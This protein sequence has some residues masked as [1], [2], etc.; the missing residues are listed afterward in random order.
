MSKPFLSDFGHLADT[1]SAT[2]VLDGTCV[3]SPG[4]DPCLQEF[5][6]CLQR[7]ESS[8][9]LGPAMTTVTPDQDRH[10][11]RTQDKQKAAEPSGL[12]FTHHEA[13]STCLPLNGIN[14]LL[15]NLPLDCGFSPSAWQTIA[16]VKVFKKA[17]V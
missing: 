9:R 14:T 8:R 5:L 11:W 4:T 3:P 15:R 7:P 13:A 2:A 10:A 6:A 17:N 16:D 1:P 12:S